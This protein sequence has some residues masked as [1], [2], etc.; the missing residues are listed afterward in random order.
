MMVKPNRR[1]IFKIN[2]GGKTLPKDH[3]GRYRNDATMKKTFPSAQM[4]R[5]FRSFAC[6]ACF[7]I[8]EQAKFYTERGPDEKIELVELIIKICSSK[9]MFFFRFSRFVGEALA[10][11]FFRGPVFFVFFWK[12]SS[13]CVVPCY[14]HEKR[15]WNGWETCMQK[16]FINYMYTTR[17][18]RRVNLILHSHHSKQHPTVVEWMQWRERRS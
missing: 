14:F 10:I 18:W 7:G 9:D 6:A 15:T 1:L 8:V 13:F 2:E 4:R 16:T 5:S 12:P 17:R 3:A 11:S